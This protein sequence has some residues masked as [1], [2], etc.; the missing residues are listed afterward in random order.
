MAL[1]ISANVLYRKSFDCCSW[2]FRGCVFNGCLLQMSMGKVALLSAEA[3]SFGMNRSGAF[4]SSAGA[5]SVAAGVV[6]LAAGDSAAAGVFAAGAADSGCFSVAAGAG[7]AAGLGGSCDQLLAATR[8]SRAASAGLP[9]RT[10]KYSGTLAGRFIRVPRD[11]EPDLLRLALGVVAPGEPQLR[12]ARR[13]PAR[14]A[15]HVAGAGGWA[16][17]IGRRRAAQVGRHSV[18]I[19]HPFGHVPPHVIQPQGTGW[20]AAHGRG[21]RYTV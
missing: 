2:I 5:P 6:V 12:N 20:K 19:L 18:E 21:G 11:P 15:H 13:A 16:G 9:R 3:F 17:R 4:S 8:S 10:V 14:P 1:T 7:S